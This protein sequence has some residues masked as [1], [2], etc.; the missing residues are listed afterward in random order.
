M[1][2]FSCHNCYYFTFWK[3]KINKIH[4]KILDGFLPIEAHSTKWTKNIYT[5][6]YINIYMYIYIC[7]YICIY[8]YV[9]IYIYTNYRS[10]DHFE[11]RA[12]LKGERTTLGW[13]YGSKVKRSYQ[14]NKEK[15]HLTHKQN[16]KKIKEVLTK[17]GK[18]WLPV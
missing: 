5:Y 17:P 8:M 7:I 10:F 9:Y 3:R 12:V 6:I 1:L 13:K 18:L 4:M 16:I 11:D 2:N 14:S 15:F